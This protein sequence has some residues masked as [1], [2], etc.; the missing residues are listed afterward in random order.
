MDSA[1]SGM[2]PVEIMSDELC[3]LL[4]DLVMLKDMWRESSSEYQKER[5]L[6]EAREKVLEKPWL[7]DSNPKWVIRFISTQIPPTANR[8]N[9]C[10]PVSR[11]AS[12][13][14]TGACSSSCCYV[15]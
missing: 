2:D 6:L 1:D 5:F 8:V 7:N 3:D 13:L 10:K 15:S 4:F 11:P 9:P 12:M 14:T